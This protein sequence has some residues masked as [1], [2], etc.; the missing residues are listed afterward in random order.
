MK[1]L[2]IAQIAPFWF[3][4]PPKDYGGTERIVSFITEELVK[5]GHDVTLFAAD[6]SQTKAKLIS[7]ITSDMF[8]HIEFYPDT[9]YSTINTYV[10]SHVFH[11]ANEFDIIHSH[12][13]YFS[14][15]FSDL[16]NTPVVH[17]LHNQLPN[18]REPA[19]EI[20]RKFHHLNY[21]SISQEFQT[22]FDLNYIGNVYH[23]LHLENFPFSLDGGDSLFW[24]GR[25]AKRKGELEAIET[26][27]KTGKKL[28]LGVS[29]RPDTQSFLMISKRISKKIFRS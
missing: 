4:V 18:P 11:H 15:Y 9:N 1:K 20:Y 10:N 25:A 8:K 17:T 19:N 13:G 24:I 26:A 21:I 16:V 14:F 28:L 5:R 2:R 27:H 6:D 3:S 7:P 12:A 22:H 29:V 23:G